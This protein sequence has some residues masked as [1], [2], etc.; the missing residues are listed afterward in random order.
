MAPEPSPPPSSRSQPGQDWDGKGDRSTGTKGCLRDSQAAPRETKMWGFQEIR[1][2]V[3]T[4]C[5]GNRGPRWLLFLLEVQAGL[6]NTRAALKQG[7]SWPPDPWPLLS[8]P[9]LGFLSPRT[10]TLVPFTSS[11]LYLSWLPHADIVLRD[12][13]SLSLG[14]RGLAWPRQHHQERGF[15]RKP[16]STGRWQRLTGQFWREGQHLG[17]EVQ[18]PLALVWHHPGPLRGRSH[19]FSSPAWMR[20]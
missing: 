7:S 2:A 5:V 19:S 18:A 9:T 4:C 11:L 10:P 20:A 14:P 6:S 16:W 13:L 12:P 17:P 1:A 8:L 15:H 3:L